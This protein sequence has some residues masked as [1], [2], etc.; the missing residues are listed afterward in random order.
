M[1]LLIAILLAGVLM[2]LGS[3][4]VWVVIAGRQRREAQ[5]AY[6]AAVSAMRQVD[7]EDVEIPDALAALSGI[8][9]ADFAR[10]PELA[11]TINRTLQRAEVRLTDAA[12]IEEQLQERISRLIEVLGAR[13]DLR[14]TSVEEPIDY[15]MDLAELASS[16]EIIDPERFDMLR[17]VVDVAHAGRQARVR[18]K[19]YAIRMAGEVLAAF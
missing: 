16:R 6:S 11:A 9:I 8:A 5:A 7:D 17:V 13:L 10:D 3:G 15:L 12:R 4:A 14:P 19:E 1:A 18:D 2:L